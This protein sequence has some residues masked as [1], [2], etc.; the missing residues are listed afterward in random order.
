MAFT[1]GILTI[2]DKGAQGEREDLSGP[3]IRALV[4]P[5]GGQVVESGIVADEQP[6]IAETL[7]L[8]AGCQPAE[9]HP[10]HRRHRLCA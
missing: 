2:S 4:E 6:L 5:R 10:D 3:A 8:W 1:V 9:P 7:T